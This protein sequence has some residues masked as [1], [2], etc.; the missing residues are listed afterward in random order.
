MSNGSSVATEFDTADF[1]WAENCGKQQ[2]TIMKSIQQVTSPRLSSFTIRTHVFL[3]RSQFVESDKPCTI[4][5]RLRDKISERRS[6]R[7]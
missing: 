1:S 7:H 6:N 3:K 4:P 2:K 5:F